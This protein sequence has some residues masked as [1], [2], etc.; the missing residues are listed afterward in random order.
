VAL[1]EKYQMK[2]MF[3]TVRMC[4]GDK[5]DAFFGSSAILQSPSPHRGPSLFFEH[6]IYA[7]GLEKR[8]TKDFNIFKTYL[9]QVC[10]FGGT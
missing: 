4:T 2:K 3:A 8:E 6:P 5:P 10:F 9:Q 7:I 1:A